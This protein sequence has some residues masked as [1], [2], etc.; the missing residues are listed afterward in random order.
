MV[1]LKFEYGNK[2][3]SINPYNTAIE[4]DLLIMESFEN[5]DLKDALQVL[6]LSKEEVQDLTL[7]EQMALMF[8]FRAVSV[9]EEMNVKYKCRHC[10]KPNETTVSIED[11][12]KKSKSDIKVEQLFKKVTED[13]LHEFVPDID[14][15]ELTIDEFDELLKKVEKAA[16][17]FDFVKESICM[18][19]HKPNHI[20]FEN[21]EKILSYMSE[22]SLVSLYQTY[23]D[24]TFFGKYSKADIDSMIP[25]ERTIFIGLLNKT[26]EE[27]NK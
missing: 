13:N 4:K 9:G 24:L 15:D 23:N 10:E 12:I 11:N 1:K 21:P 8:K 2:S 6:G 5:Y 25:F 26:R 20:S 16:V 19:C 3:F 7:D 17:G 22:D 18:H 14:V 27:L